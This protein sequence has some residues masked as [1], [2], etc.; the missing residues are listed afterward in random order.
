VDIG[1]SGRAARCAGFAADIGAHEVEEC[2]GVGVGG[3][4]REEAPLPGAEDGRGGVKKGRKKD[5]GEERRGESTEAI[6]WLQRQ[7]RR[8]T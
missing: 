3:E 1:L 4:V 8:V 2:A 7:P 6:P 5:E